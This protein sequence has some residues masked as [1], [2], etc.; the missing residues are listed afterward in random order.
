MTLNGETGPLLD[1]SDDGRFTVFFN[2]AE[3]V[4]RGYSNTALGYDRQTRSVAPAIPKGL[5]A[6]NWVIR[7]YYAT[8]IGGDGSK[9]LFEFELRDGEG[10]GICLID[11]AAGTLL[12]T[13]VV[14]N[15][16]PAPSF[17][18]MDLDS[19]GWTIVANLRE[20]DAESN[21]PAR[22]RLWDRA[23]DTLNTLPGQP[24]SLSD[25]VRL[26][27]DGR[28]AA[29]TNDL[30]MD[31]APSGNSAYD[32]DITTGFLRS[33]SSPSGPVFINDLSISGQ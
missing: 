16:G 4:M 17:T 15:T 26:L 8:R 20:A 31:I 10:V 32:L 7:D 21:C 24:A 11:R 19:D 25:T 1:S 9:V 12:D 23:A 13:A 6:Q 14:E 27:A 28:I 29:F 33:R 22:L 5:V 3:S 18:G 30:S 2:S